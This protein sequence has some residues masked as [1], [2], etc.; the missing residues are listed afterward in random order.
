MIK[1]CAIVPLFVS[2]RQAKQQRISSAN[3]ISIRIDDINKSCLQQF[4][5]HWECLED[6]NQQLWQCRPAEWK[7]NKCVFE[8]LVRH[9]HNIPAGHSLSRLSC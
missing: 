4:R 5:A 2:L 1:C 6:N 9:H 8:N 3:P 7:L